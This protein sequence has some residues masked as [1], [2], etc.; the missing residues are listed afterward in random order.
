[1]FSAATERSGVGEPDEPGV[2]PPRLAERESMT[3]WRPRERDLK[4]Y[5]HFDKFLPL[6][7]I[8]RI[9]T[10]PE[11]VRMNKF[12]PFP[13]QVRFSTRRIHFHLLSSSFGAT[14]RDVAKEL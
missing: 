11:R 13:H 4:H 5:P 10:D 14:I 2:L 9:V 6:D 8:E 1:M 3:D 12:Y 7:E